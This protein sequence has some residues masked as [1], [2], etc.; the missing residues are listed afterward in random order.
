MPREARAH[1][2]CLSGF[3]QQALRRAGEIA[4]G[5]PQLRKYLRVSTFALAAWLGG[6]EQPPLDIF[7]SAV[8]LIVLQEIEDLR[9]N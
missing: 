4:G 1:R 7:L 9:R 8:D 6:V 5:T 2:V 3:C